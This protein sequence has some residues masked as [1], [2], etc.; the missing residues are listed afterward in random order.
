M[1]DTF[2]YYGSVVLAVYKALALVITIVALLGIWYVAVKS[3][4]IR[5]V[6][7]GDASAE[8]VKDTTPRVLSQLKDTTITRWHKII[9]RL[10]KQE[11][12]DFKTAIIEADGLVDAALRAQRFPGETMADRMRAI[13]PERAISTDELWRAHKVRNEIAHDPHYAVSPREGH[14]MMRI[15]KK[16]LEEMGAL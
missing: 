3:A 11:E 2:L 7:R 9:E 1:F 8:P 14:D 12:K 15:Y 5:R 4:E 6:R 16:V 13:G 10:D